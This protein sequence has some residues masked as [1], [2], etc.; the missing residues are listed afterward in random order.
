MQ[1]CNHVL[2]RHIPC[3]IAIIACSKLGLV[4]GSGAQHDPVA[5]LVFCGPSIGSVDLSIV[6]G[7]FIV[8]DGC[9][10]TLDLEV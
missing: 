9:L 5:A 10:L 2:R 3:M 1:D 6:N 8:R 4:L 7:E